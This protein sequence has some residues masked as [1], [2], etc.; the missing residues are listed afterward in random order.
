M[1]AQ[2]IGLEVGDQPVAIDGQAILCFYQVV[3]AWKNRRE[4]IHLINCS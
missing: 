3:G 4:S 1:P 2:E